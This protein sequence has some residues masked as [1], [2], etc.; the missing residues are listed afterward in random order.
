M[1]EINLNFS[2]FKCSENFKTCCIARVN[3]NA[4]RDFLDYKNSGQQTVVQ[5]VYYEVIKQQ[6]AN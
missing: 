2:A 6:T 3:K 1:T 4:L 5:K